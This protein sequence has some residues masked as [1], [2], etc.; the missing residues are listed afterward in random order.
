[1]QI[2]MQMEISM[3]YQEELIKSMAQ[4]DEE[5]VLK[6]IQLMLTSGFSRRPYAN[7]LRKALKKSDI[8]SQTGNILS[9]T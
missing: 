4:L 7:I 2:N 5:N 8:I 6:Y 1:M 9:P 3:N